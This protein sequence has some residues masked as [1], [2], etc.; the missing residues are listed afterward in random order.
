LAVAADNSQTNFSDVSIRPPRTA[1]G[2]LFFCKE[3]IMNLSSLRLEIDRIDEQIVD[4]LSERAS[5]AQEIG[6]LKG[7][8]G[9]TIKDKHREEAVLFHVQ[10]YNQGP[11]SNDDIIAVF[12]RIIHACRGL[13]FLA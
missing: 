7:N 6:T 5:L 12:K 8:T 9:I 2:G 10:S 4:L 3:L 1:S 13:Q 11:L